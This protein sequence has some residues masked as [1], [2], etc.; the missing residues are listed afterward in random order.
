MSIA[1]AMP[2]LSAE[3]RIVQGAFE[4]GCTINELAPYVGIHRTTFTEKLNTGSLP[5]DVAER[6]L[7]TLEAM[8]KLRYK[9]GL[10][11]AWGQIIVCKPVVEQALLEF[12]EQ[13]DP[14][15]DEFYIIST[16]SVGYFSCVRNGEVVSV[17]S[18]AKAAAF[19]DIQQAG[20]AARELNFRFKTRA[21][22]I[23]IQ[24]RSIKR[25]LSELTSTFEEVGLTGNPGP[26]P[27]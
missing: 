11:V 7:D 14:C 9:A 20:T 22:F 4:V 24:N 3:Q 8:K 15:P 23:P 19:A 16:S 6:V 25:K 21:D 27:K 5:N 2:T 12:R 18:I 17:P 10:P 1:M 13:K 26:K